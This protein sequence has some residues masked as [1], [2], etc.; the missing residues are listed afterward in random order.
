MFRIIFL[1][2][3]AFVLGVF[4]SQTQSIA[5]TPALKGCAVDEV[6]IRGDW[7][8]MRFRV[9]VADDD[10]ERGQGLMFVE[11][12]ARDKGMIFVWDTPQHARFWMRNTYIPLDMLF[13]GADGV[14]KHIHHEAIPHDETVI[15][16]GPGVL[17]VLE[18]NGGMSRSFGIDVGSELQHPAFGDDAAWPCS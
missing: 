10:A 5:L 1:T 12:M 7:G 18:I 14:V 17:A 2:V 8:Q 15:D 3:F 9:D 4:G 13:V 16:G 11:E 6:S